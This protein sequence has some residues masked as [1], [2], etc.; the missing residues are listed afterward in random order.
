[1][2]DQATTWTPALTNALRVHLLSWRRATVLRPGDPALA[3]VAG[4]YRALTGL[5]P[6]AARAV[7]AP[8][9]DALDERAE[10]TSV[11]LATPFDPVVILSPAAVADPITEA[12]TLAH[13]WCHVRQVADGRVASVVD[14]TSGELRARAEADATACALWLRFVLTGEL[15]DA[16]PTLG[17]LYHLDAGDHELA[18][19]VMR[20]H[21][22]T[23]RAGLVPPLDV[24]VRLAR[25]L[26]ATP[27]EMPP[28]IR[29]RIP[30]TLPETP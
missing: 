30:R 27:Y 23:I 21:L 22:A 7:A 29:G 4:L 14:Y 1:M 25:W 2:S 15:P 10:R 20:S 16:A 28:A 6:A 17:D 11:T 26:R 9:L 5:L 24:C 13:E 18:R 3:A 12:C 8:V 19:G